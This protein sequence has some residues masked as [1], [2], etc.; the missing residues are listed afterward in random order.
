MSRSRSFTVSLRPRLVTQWPD[1]AAVSDMGLHSTSTPWKESMSTTQSF[2][3][4]FRPICCISC[5]ALNNL[6]VAAHC[7]TGG[8]S[9]ALTLL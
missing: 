9:S 6:F 7:V 3:N 4:G 5:T 1:S 8:T 2:C